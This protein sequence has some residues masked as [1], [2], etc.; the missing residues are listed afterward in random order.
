VELNLG[1][2]LIPITGVVLLLR[3]V[4][5]GSYWEALQFSPAVAAVTLLAC[6]MSIRWAIDQFNS[7]SVLFRE[8]ERLDLGLWLR[9]LLSNRKPTPT[10][11][12]AVGCGTLILMI[13]FFL[14][15]AMTTPSGFGGFVHTVLV[16]Q[17]AVIA[18]PALLMTF[19]LTR[20][21]RQT[22]LLK[23]PSWW[24]I[25]AAALLAVVLHP[26]ANRLQMVVE[27]L[28]PIN[29]SVRAALEEMQH[30]IGQANFWSLVLILGVVPA[31]C[32]ELAF[33][34]F[35]LSGFRHL[36]HRWRAIVYSALFFG[37]THGVLQQSMIASLL[38]V[39]IGYLAVQSGSIFPG[40]AF[41]VLHNTLAVANSRIAPEW[42][43][44]SPLARMFV[45]PVDGGGC[46]FTWLTVVVGSLIG[47]LL[48]IWFGRSP[49]PMSAEESLEAA[50]ERGEHDDLSP[51]VEQ[52]PSG[53]VGIGRLQNEI[54]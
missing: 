35:I 31:L 12:A 47:V 11:A 22:L 4:L 5:E 7:E 54:A 8:S 1:N 37:L 20:S 29:E 17:L 21:P 26:A 43:P 42:I 23:L 34:G 28:Y 39:V 6:W 53:A 3:S 19:L 18:V 41:H 38:G 13:K 45:T 49:C 16:T 2:S 40:I 51:T 10:V 24:A 27:R 46:L 25:P 14:S 33:R 30:V 52:A 15:S 36:G 44:D 48:L 9:H 32:E 50:I